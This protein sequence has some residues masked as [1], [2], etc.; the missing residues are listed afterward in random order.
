MQ[1]AHLVTLI[2]VNNLGECEAEDDSEGGVVALGRAD[3]PVVG[4][5]QFAV[6]GELGGSGGPQ[7]ERQQQQ[8]EHITHPG[9]RAGRDWEM[10]VLFRR[11][12]P[13]VPVLRVSSPANCPHHEGGPGD[14]KLAANP[15]QLAATG[16][17][18]LSRVPPPPTHRQDAL[19]VK[20][21]KLRAQQSG[22]QY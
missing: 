14:L 21:S 9:G 8:T 7:Q 2:Y 22:T 13:P 15:L 1:P 19:A 17:G 20:L 16:I 5:E 10:A 3:R 4:G 18:R 11:A 12:A 6:E